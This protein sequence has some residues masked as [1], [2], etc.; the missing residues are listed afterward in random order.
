M[1][2]KNAFT[3]VELLVVIAIIGMLIALL[4]PAVNS[5]REAGRRTTCKN[6]LRQQAL[7]VRSY[8]QQFDEQL[9]AIWQKGA[10]QPWETFSW[11]VALLPF[12]EED[13]RYDRI[14]Q[15]TLPLDDPKNLAAANTVATFNCP[16]SPSSPRVIT[17]YAGYQNLQLGATDYVAVFDVRAPSGVHS[18]TWFGGQSPDMIPGPATGADISSI[19]PAAPEADMAIGVEPDLDSAKIR[20]IPSTLRRVRDGLSNTVLVVEQA[21]KPARVNPYNE[22]DEDSLA[23]E[24]AWLTSEYASFYAGAVNQDNHSGP[25]G[26]HSGASIAMCD[27]SVHFWPREIDAEVMFALLTREGSEIISDSDW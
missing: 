22:S 15:A 27:G 2:R 13:A 23:T 21:G 25:Y 4:L 26:Y 11:R 7:A 6:H 1:R 9:P 8:A 19:G 5:V 24:G 20:K 3:L 14:N 17:Q 16:S 12:M 10:S 18:G